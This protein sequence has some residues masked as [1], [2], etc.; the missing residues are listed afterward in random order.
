MTPKM[1]S[2]RKLETH[3]HTHTHTH[4]GSLIYSTSSVFKCASGCKW[5]EWNTVVTVSKH[6]Q[7]EQHVLHVCAT[8]RNPADLLTFAFD[9]HTFPLHVSCDSHLQQLLPLTPSTT[10][11]TTRS[12]SENRASWWCDAKMTGCGVNQRF[13]EQNML[14]WTSSAWNTSVKFT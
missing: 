13:A 11:P 10:S 4:W 1:V 7:K 14:D 9:L 5:V 2:C 6:L 12:N 8:P 3:T